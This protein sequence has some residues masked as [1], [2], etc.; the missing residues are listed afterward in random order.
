MLA[1]LATAQETPS[2]TVAGAVKQTLTLTAADLARMPRAAVTTKNDGIEVNY[3]GVW[4]HDV[5]KAAG[6]PAGAELRSRALTTYVMAEASDGYQ[7]VFSLAE[8]DPAFVDSQVL[9]A[10]KAGGKALF[11][12]QGSFRLIA[13][14][15][16]RGARSIRML[17]KLEVIQA[18]K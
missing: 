5:L 4:L 15:E 18:K 9:L 14:K 11:G 12:A 1:G 8:L 17:Q 7:V 6:V 16:K 2:V 3:E 10:D 13:R